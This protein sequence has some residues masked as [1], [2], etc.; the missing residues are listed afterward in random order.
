MQHKIDIKNLQTLCKN[1]AVRPTRHAFSRLMQR[2]IALRD[3]VY[4]IENGEIIEQYPE[5]YPVPSCLVLGL[6]PYPL[7]VVCSI[8]QAQLWIITAY[9]PNLQEWEPDYKTRKSGKEN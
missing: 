9:K 2:G 6:E 5:D 1:K 4:V 8:Y 7:H 3:V